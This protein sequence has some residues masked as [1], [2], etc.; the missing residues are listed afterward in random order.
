MK[1]R[2][3]SI[4]LILTVM[5]SGCSRPA[6]TEPSV[7]EPAPEVEILPV[8]PTPEIIQSAPLSS[9]E[10][11]QMTSEPATFLDE[12]KAALFAGDYELAIEKFSAVLQ[13]PGQPSD[14]PAALLGLTRTKIQMG[15]CTGALADI[16]S[17]INEYSDSYER[18]NAQY[19]LGECLVNEEDYV[20]AAEAYARYLDFRPG[21]IDTLINEKSGDAYFSA[22]KYPEAINA[23]NAALAA[24]GTTAAT[25]IQIKIAKSL[26]AQ[27]Y[28]QRSDYPPAGII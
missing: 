7:I 23:Y 2:I 19:F 12:G 26:K 6:P 15:D 13:S 27:G 1:S 8:S 5:I 28:S 3:V 10:P 22:E 17:I 21:L 9:P 16:R 11:I 24:A 25:R 20:E 14:P 4:I 18:A